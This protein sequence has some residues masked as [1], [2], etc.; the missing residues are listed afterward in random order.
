LV[1]PTAIPVIDR[2]AL[3]W[4]LRVAACAPL[5]FPTAMLPNSNDID[6]GAMRAIGAAETPTPVSEMIC[7]ELAC[8]SELSQIWIWSGKDPVVVGENTISRVQLLPAASGQLL[9]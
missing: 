2:A 6:D 3:P 5:A 4:L 9:N 8:K 7:S 1:P